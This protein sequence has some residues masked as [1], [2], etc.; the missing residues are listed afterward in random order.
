M[1]KRTALLLLS[2]LCLLAGSFLSCR[3]RPPRG[4][5]E[6]EV[7]SI[8]YNEHSL[9]NYRLAKQYIAQGRYE[10]ARYR[11]QQAHNAARTR[12][13]QQMIQREL[14]NCDRLIQANR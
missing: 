1:P 6:Q 5:H 3:T 13:E 12:P 10:L 7:V 9:V 14:E 11:L 2:L 8:P 4:W